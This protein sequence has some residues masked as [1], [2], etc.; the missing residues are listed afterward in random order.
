MSKTPDKESESPL[1]TDVNIAIKLL[2]YPVSFFAGYQA[3]AASIRNALYKNLAV[4]GV[5]K[6]QK[7]R[8]KL[9]PLRKTI[10]TVENG[11][12][13]Y[14][15]KI[16]EKINDDLR[17]D[18][19]KRIEKWGFNN[20]GD[21]WKGLNVNQQTEACVLGMTV[22]GIILGSMLYIANSKGLLNLLERS[23]RKKDDQQPA[24]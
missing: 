9:D 19:K 3:T 13:L 1:A 8:L 21:Y 20:V 22:T 15:P 10:Q 5:F 24:K 16:M 12:A 18:V 2:A 6:E 11:E 7:E 14:V 17:Q 23:E 4:T